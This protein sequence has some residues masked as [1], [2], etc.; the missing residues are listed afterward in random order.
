[1]CSFS[2]NSL[3]SSVDNDEISD[4]KK[5]CD[6]VLLMKD[7]LDSQNTSKFNVD[8]EIKKKDSVLTK[9]IKRL[10]ARLKVQLS[11]ATSRCFGLLT[12]SLALYSD[13]KRAA[14][15][16]LVIV[17][18][19]VM[20]VYQ[21]S[22]TDTICWVKF[23]QLFF[24]H[25]R[26]SFMKQ[27]YMYRTHSKLIADLKRLGFSNNPDVVDRHVELHKQK[28][29][30]LGL[31]EPYVENRMCYDKKSRK[32][33]ER[34]N[35]VMPEM[36]RSLNQRNSQAILRQV[37]KY[38]LFFTAITT[39]RYAR[40]LIS[41]ERDW[42]DEDIGVMNNLE[43]KDNFYTSSR[44]QV[45]DFEGDSALSKELFDLVAYSR[46]YSNKFCYCKKNVVALAIAS[47]QNGEPHPVVSSKNGGSRHSARRVSTSSK[48]STSVTSLSTPRKKS[49]STTTTTTTTTSGNC[50]NCFHLL[51]FS[52]PIII[53]L[54]NH[55]KC[56]EEKLGGRVG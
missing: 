55:K 5:L 26:E 33:V 46:E 25:W 37:N 2:E 53:R 24:G 6:E 54:I 50:K 17:V 51:F 39:N 38:H 4:F 8:D 16:K 31:T 35:N 40:G 43:M 45:N 20:K 42:N 41:G 1:M 28:W 14:K 29:R 44:I 34:L 18:V 48:S 52:Q 11:N 22:Q 15:V 30:D 7:V 12:Q 19:K 27:S 32:M 23:L 3:H 36:V 56:L 21:E 13:E 10:A 49:S 47:E 9:K